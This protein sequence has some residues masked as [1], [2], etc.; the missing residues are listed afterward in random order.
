MI[1]VIRGIMACHVG[2][3]GGREGAGGRGGWAKHNYS[4]EAGL[5]QSATARKQAWIRA[6]QPGSGPGPERYSQEAGLDRSATARKLAWI[7]ALQ[8]GSRPGLEPKMH[9]RGY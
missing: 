7:R 2:W 4:Q 9:N 1:G 8:P 5:D 6:L 3:M